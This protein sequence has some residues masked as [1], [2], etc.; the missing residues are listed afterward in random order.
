MKKLLHILL[1]ICSSGGLAA[2][3]TL[4]VVTKTVQKTV[5]WKNGFELVVT[6]EKAEVLVVP[7]L[8]N[9][10]S[11]KAEL[12]AK[13]PRLDS[14]K[15]DLE[16]WKIVVSNVGKKI[17]VRAYIGLPGGGVLPTSNMKA[18][19]TISIPVNCPVSLSNKFGKARL[20]NLRGPVVLNGE[21]CDFSLVEL[22]GNI[23]LESQYGNV[24]GE[25]LSGKVDINAKR[26][27][28]NLTG[29]SADCS[30]HSEYGK[31]R[32]K[33]EKQTGNLSVQG[34]KSDVTVDLA[35]NSDHNISLTAAYG[36]VNTPDNLGFNTKKS[37][38]N[39]QKATLKKGDKSPYVAVETSF[40]SIKVE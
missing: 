14:A 38:K 19:I 9:T 29:L 18:K 13:H 32:V 21:F 31:V 8:V 11:V 39:A 28:V 25:K 33:A 12:T 10:I 16:Y 20:E 17:F 30:I 1:L 27:D 23:Q 6:G 5:D 22:S 2:Q 36:E 3:T 7:S 26:A 4:Q 37:S 15:I 24:E 34:N 40:G 35:Q